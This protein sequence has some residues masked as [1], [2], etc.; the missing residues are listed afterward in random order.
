M[1][2]GADDGEPALPGWA[3][4]ALSAELGLVAA[5]GETQEA[6]F[7]AEM[8]KQVSDL[9]KEIAGFAT[10]NA[11]R[12]LL[13]VG[14]DGAILGLADCSERTGRAGL[15]QRI[16]GICAN[17]VRPA[18]TPRVRF[19]V[20]EGRVVAVIDIPKGSQPIYYSANIPYLRQITAARPMAPD[21]VVEHVL[22]WQRARGEDARPTPESR[23][24][25][26][27]AG[28]L[29]E[30]E[31]DV[32]ELRIRRLKPWTDML[33]SAA[34]FHASRAREL[35][36]SAPDSLMATQEPLEA[37]AESF[38][39]IAR[40]RPTLNSSRLE[41]EAAI[42]AI[43]ETVRTT[44]ARW[45]GPELFAD[46]AHAGQREAVRVTARQLA[47]L[48]GRIDAETKF[49]RMQE[50]QD[51]ATARGRELLRAASYGIGLGDKAAREALWDI[52]AALRELETRRLVMDGGRSQQRLIDDLAAINDRLQG[53]LEGM[54]D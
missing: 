50:L 22:A 14:D 47:G 23:Y 11:G 2:A 5:I 28:F 45:L 19:A 27:L 26:K 39:T 3:D 30:A 29:V 25:G 6:E 42:D 31:V 46:S 40:E 53:W 37:I 41:I 35:A 48:V 21:E 34:G 38:E 7:K 24:L 1:T 15:V 20:A 44:R 17:A 8:P 9:A 16:E 18:V 33:R 36:A 4:A 43:C 51:E 10:S 49:L 13:G 12:I 52:G 32:R 54:A